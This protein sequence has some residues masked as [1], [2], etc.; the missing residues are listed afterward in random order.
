MT[1][2]RGFT[3][4]ELLVVIA[5]IAILIAL[6]V[7][8]VQNSRE[9]AAGA[10]RQQSQADR[11]ALHNHH[12]A[13]KCFPPGNSKPNSFSV[14]SF[15][16]PYLEQGPL[17]SQIDFTKS[18]SANTGPMAVAI[19][20]LNCPSDP[21]SAVPAGWGGN[22]YVGNYGSGITWGG[23]GTVSNGVFFHLTSTQGPLRRYLRRHQQH[24]S[25]LRTP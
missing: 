25:I 8:A 15:L 9:A 20:V 23:D 1:R 24:G 3:L 13:K 16:L 22:S 14:H 21:Q 18:Y 17:Y 4:I 10:V 11:H 6:L 5:I 19:P 7:P 2:R 12:D